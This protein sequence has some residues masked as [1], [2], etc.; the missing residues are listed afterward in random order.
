MWFVKGDSPQCGEMSRSD[1]GDGRQLGGSGVAAG[2][3]LYRRCYE[4]GF[5]CLVLSPPQ[6]R[7]QNHPLKSQQHKKGTVPT[8]GALCLFF[9]LC[10]LDP[11]GAGSGVAAVV[12]GV[13]YGSVGAQ[14]HIIGAAALGGFNIPGGLATAYIQ[15]LFVAGKVL[16]GGILHGV[17]VAFHFVPA[18]GNLLLF[19]GFGGGAF[20][21]SGAGGGRQL[22]ALAALLC[23]GVYRVGRHIKIVFGARLG[24]AALEHK[25]AGGGSGQALCLLLGGNILV[26]HIAVGAGL[27]VP[28]QGNGAGG[29]LL[30]FQSGDGARQGVL[31]V[32]LGIGTPVSGVAPISRHLHLVQLGV[33]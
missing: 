33:C 31:G 4:R 20:G 14:A 27:F 8:N 5:R 30:R 13:A 7:E 16:L 10:S 22:G 6:H 17:A 32:H 1:R 25:V 21:G 12:A 2:G 9:L 26:H 28:L 29:G 18:H 24:A 19:G 15:G 11:H 3:G 23:L